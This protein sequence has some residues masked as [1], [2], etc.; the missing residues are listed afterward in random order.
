MKF[1][2][3]SFVLSSIFSTFIFAQTSEINIIPQPKSVT[4]LAG[5]FELNYKTKIVAFD[6]VGRKSAGLLNDLPW[7]LGPQHRDRNLG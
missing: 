5:E 6:A 2:I 7:S 1:L 3:L 4:R